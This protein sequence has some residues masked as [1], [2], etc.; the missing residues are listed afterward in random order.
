MNWQIIAIIAALIALLILFKLFTSRGGGKLARHPYQKHA[1]LFSPDEQAFF[2]ALKEAVGEEYEIFGKIPAG[3]IIVPKRD[4]AGK[5]S[6]S[7]DG[8][9]FDF[10]LCDKTAL[11][12]VCAIQLQDK[13]HPSRQAGESDPLP[14][15]CEN[16]G[17]PLV[18]FH[19]QADYETGEMRERLQKAMVKEPFH[20]METDGRKEP[21]ISN[22]EDMKF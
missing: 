9:H 20:W 12:V 18:R 17:L 21:R 19:V 14:L 2:R 11:A 22:I 16:L 6:A 15:I 4:G 13:T 8:R 3:D 10:V 5:A 7:L 1:M